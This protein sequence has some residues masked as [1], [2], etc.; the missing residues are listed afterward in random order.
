MQ[1]L[2]GH[3]TQ[4]LHIQWFRSQ[5]GIVSQEPILFDCSIRDNIAYG[6]NF[7]DV[8]MEEIIAAARQA[9][10]HTFIESLPQACSFY[11]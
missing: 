1:V 10:I 2:D 9:N 6:D 3:K 4:S 8:T 11:L 7:R 5:I